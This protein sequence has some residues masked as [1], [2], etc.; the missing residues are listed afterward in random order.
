MINESVMNLDSRLNW[1]YRFLFCI[2]AM[3]VVASAANS[4]TDPNPID[5]GAICTVSGS[6]LRALV[7]VETVSN[8]KGGINFLYE[9]TPIGG[10]VEPVFQWNNEAVQHI[11][12]GYSFLRGRV[13]PLMHIQNGNK[14]R[15]FLETG[16][17][18][19][20]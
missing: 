14:P 7:P 17:S 3:L 12:G 16:R 4:Q 2:L 20:A 9:E 5:L 19:S 1:I 6:T 13:A 11:E 18:I 8:A 10:S 15:R